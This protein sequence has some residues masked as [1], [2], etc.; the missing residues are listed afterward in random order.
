MNLGNICK[1]QVV[2]IDRHASLQQAAQRMREGHVGALV[3]T[4]DDDDGPHVT[5]IVTDRE[6]AI[7]LLARGSEGAGVQVGRLVG[8]RLVSVPEQ[9]DLS[10]AVA[11]MQAAGVRRLLVRNDKGH[12]VGMVSFDDVLQAAVAPLAGLV[13]VLRRGAAREAALRGA[14][15]QSEG[16][17]V[18]VPAESTGG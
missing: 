10:E 5:G 18:R 15:A 2:T 7:E 16:P 17:A 13:E 9:S 8:T 1:H 12:L 14:L 11:L 6:L 3:V 4:E